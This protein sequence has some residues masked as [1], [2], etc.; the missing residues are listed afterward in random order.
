MAEERNEILKTASDEV[1]ELIGDKE[2]KIL[3]LQ[4]EIA[5]MDRISDL[6]AARE[7]GEEK[8]I[9]KGMKKR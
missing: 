2:L 8:G 9:K 1:E 7:E 6:N 3:A 4:R 5:E